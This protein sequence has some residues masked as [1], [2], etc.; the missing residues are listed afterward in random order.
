M[1]G[2]NIP[3][4]LPEGYAIELL[5]ELNIP[6]VPPINLYDVCTRKDIQVHQNR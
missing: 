4:I 3:G 6:L 1:S 2:Y 5:Q